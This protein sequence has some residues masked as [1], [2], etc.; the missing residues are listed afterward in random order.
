MSISKDDYPEEQGVC[1]PTKLVERAVKVLF[2]GRVSIHLVMVALF[3]LPPV[4]T[5][6]LV[7]GLGVFV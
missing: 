3:Q 7:C 1:Y 6:D 5:G 2:L 4:E